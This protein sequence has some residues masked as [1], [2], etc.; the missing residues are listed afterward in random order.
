MGLSSEQMVSDMQLRFGR[1]DGESV[2]AGEVDGTYI[3]A[4][5]ADGEDTISS[6]ETFGPSIVH[7]KCF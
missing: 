3:T 1:S 2:D 7:R 6:D 5:T 4:Y